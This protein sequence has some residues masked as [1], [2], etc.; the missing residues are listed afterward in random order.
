MKIPEN[1]DKKQIARNTA[2]AVLAGIMGM[3]LVSIFTHNWNFLDLVKSFKV[4]LLVLS[5]VMMFANWFLEAY[6]LKIISN[7]LDYNLNMRDALDVFL[8]G[9][10]FSRIT[11]FGGG[12]GEP[13]QMVV[14]SQSENVKPGDSAAIIAIKMFIGTFVRLSVFLL[15]PL[16]ILIAKP[17]WGMTRNQNI[18]VNSGIALTIFLFAVLIAALFKPQIAEKTASFILKKNFLKKIF[19]EK[20]I[21]NA[22]NAL[23]KT[24]NDFSDARAKIF[25]AKQKMIV[26]AFIAS[27]FSWSLVLFTPVVL[28]RGLGI[29]SPWPEIIITA[30]IFYISSAYIPTPGG[31]GTAEIEMLAL[32]SRLIPAPLLGVFIIT[33]RLFTHYFLLI[34]GGITMLFK[35]KRKPKHQ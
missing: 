31:S 7:S 12:G 13:V 11:P 19:K 23:K 6:T 8:V 20:Q 26:Y 24:V 15:I 4:S 1:F 35:L 2:F 33:W 9:G 17:T 28:M 16:W 14:L 25:K 27:F 3:V 29:K 32:F 21:L 34:T 22:V 5:F 30:I 10:F 18:L